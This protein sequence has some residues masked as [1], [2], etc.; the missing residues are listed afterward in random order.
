MLIY[1]SIMYKNAVEP[2]TALY[3]QTY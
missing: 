3:Y 2:W 1:Y